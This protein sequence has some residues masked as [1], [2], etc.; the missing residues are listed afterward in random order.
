MANMIHALLAVTRDRP[1]GSTSQSIAL[2]SLV[3]EMV[4]TM[5]MK[6]L[7]T[8]EEGLAWAGELLP[9]GSPAFVIPHAGA[10]LPR[11]FSM[12]GEA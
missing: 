2:H 4:E 8:L 1:I 11:V 12:E 6:P 5:G 9:A 3:D 7:A 10:L